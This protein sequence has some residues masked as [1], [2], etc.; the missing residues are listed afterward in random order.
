M[1]KN[2]PIK[3]LLRILVPVLIILTAL[4]Y[5]IIPLSAQEGEPFINHFSLAEVP[6]NRI[7]SISQDME[8][9]MVFSGNTGVISFDSEEWN[10][11]SVPN[12]PKAVSTDSVLPLI[13][14]GGRGFYGYLLKTGMGTYEYHNLAKENEITGDINRIYQTSK[15]VIYYG[16]DLIVLA[17]RN[18]LYNLKQFRPDTAHI[19]SGLLIFRDNAYVNILG[20]GIY[21]LSF[22]G[23]TQVETRIDFSGSEILFGI[24]YAD[25]NALIGLD[26]NTLFWFNGANF[27][28]VD[29]EDQNYLEESFMKDAAWLNENIFAISTV[30][31]GCMIVDV[32]TGETRNIINYQTGLP[33]DEIFAIGK[34]NN[35]G[36]W[37]SHQYGLSRIDVRLPI[38]SYENYPG[39]EGNLTAVA[40][41]DST[42]YVSTNEG[43]FFLEEKKDYLEEEIIVKVTTPVAPAKRA[44]KSKKEA[45]AEVE[46]Q[47]PEEIQDEQE[48]S[49]KEQRRLKREARKASKNK[50]EVITLED[51]GTDSISV[52]KPKGLKALFQK[53][54]ETVAAE[55]KVQEEKLSVQDIE[56]IL[57]PAAYRTRYVKQKIY[58]LQ[59]IS[60]EFTRLGD[61]EEKA[62]DLVPVGS[63]L[64][65]STNGGLY[66]I[67]GRELRII[68][69]DWYIKSIFP[70]RD[71]SRIYV[72]TDESAYQL[73][74]NGEQWETKRDFAYIGEEIF[75]VCEEQDSTI[76]L[77]CDN[78]SY[79]ITALNNAIS[80]VKSFD[81][82]EEYYD[83][84]T[85]RNINDTVYFFL[86]SG[87]YYFMDDSIHQ[88]GILGGKNLSR[89]QLST[90]AV[91]WVETGGRWIS[92][93]NQENYKVGVDSY[94]NLFGDIADL[95]LDPEG[96]I[97][98][99]S[100]NSFLHKINSTNVNEYNPGFD[101]FLNTVYN[102]EKNYSLDQLHFDYYDRS[103]E[104]NISAPFYLKDNSTSYQFYAEGMSDG[105][106]DWSGSGVL[107]F[108]VL[109]M[110]KFTLHVRA[111]NVLNQVTEISSIPILIKPPWWLS[112]PFLVTSGILLISLILLIIR[113]RV[114]KLRRDKAVLETK[115]KERTAE[116]QR[117]KDEISD[118]KKEIMDSIYY[119]RRIQKA[120]LPSDKKIDESL[121]EHFI[122]YKPRDIVSGDFYWI[123]TMENRIIFAAVDCT[124][125]GVPGAFMSML[126][127]AFLNEIVSRNRRPSAGR[128]LDNLR[129]NVKETLSQAEEGG[130]KD[131]MDIALCIYDPF[132]M[133]LQY[134]GAHNPLY[135]IRN[136]EFS[137]Y[138]ADTMPIG[139]HIVEEK[140]FKNHNI[141][142]EKGDCIYVFSDGFQDQFG[143][144]AGKKFL[145]RSMKQLFCDIHKHPMPKQKEIIDETMQ[146]WI[147][148]QE[149][150][151]DM[152]ILGLR[153]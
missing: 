3:A 38:R 147:K 6:G 26:N 53:R 127:V 59:S 30:L 108:P 65:I 18:D 21:E 112:T 16:E 118:Q 121:P 36:L 98:V 56:D 28:R 52:K 97:W 114:R 22:S 76:W 109:P 23:W 35:H 45:F 101:L 74:L 100:E 29:L 75:S 48:I 146:R 25:S 131:G 58:S 78:R 151:D 42:L 54:P 95:F 119:A 84:V 69:E 72:I 115:V 138:K 55:D 145:S 2:R 7:S 12:I 105:W 8:N 143:G 80:D 50:E 148:G 70:S 128:I 64:L 107:R 126:G 130:T 133:T 10:I 94:L 87:I 5:P 4:Q 81:F 27:N 24:E 40:Y 103:I 39:L 106:S 113:W 88:T 31:G 129:A 83:P 44:E 92:F 33:D 124:G 96:N 62:K 137:E 49:P 66:E 125:H 34:D 104:F 15:H 136:G 79:R 116:I 11:H 86:S 41:L 47:V 122:Y 57:Q 73:V 60:H 149:Q 46:S 110:G 43:I 68:R 134:A 153:I 32:L 89:I 85:M 77:G 117:Q 140:N 102:D 111:K 20:K 152:I 144:P 67:I 19:F 61:F 135:L 71:S 99:V 139:I 123:S 63:R 132:K 9:T 37:V 141:K 13:Y 91:A 82:H 90:C 51:D 14:V 17:R 142:V 120:V 93:N 150:I 1:Y